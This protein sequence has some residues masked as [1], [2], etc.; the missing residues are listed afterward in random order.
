MVWRVQGWSREVRVRRVKTQERSGEF[1]GQGKWSVPGESRLRKGQES[2][3]G[4]GSRESG[5]VRYG[6]RQE[7]SGV[8]ISRGLGE[9]RNPKRY[10]VRKGQ[11]SGE[12]TSGDFRSHEK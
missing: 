1:R 2:L 3:G 4:R 9:K 7:I 11:G 10:M 8:T 5:E 12:V 6:S